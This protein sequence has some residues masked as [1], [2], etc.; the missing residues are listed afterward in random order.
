VQNISRSEDDRAFVQTMLDLARR[1]K[2]A[3][4]AEW[5]QDEATAQMLS[6]WG[7]DYLQGALFGLAASDRPWAN[8]N[9]PSR[10]A[11]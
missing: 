2:L 1:M 11:G 6:S 4:V 8:N 7:C 9:E 3:T 5:V 10:A